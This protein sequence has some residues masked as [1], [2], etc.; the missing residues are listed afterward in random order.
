MTDAVLALVPAY[1]SL[2]L[3]LAVGLSCLG[4]P[5]PG[6]VAL[7]LSGSF[8]ATGEMA[9]LPVLI[10]ALAGAVAGDLTGYAIGRAGGVRLTGWIDSRRSLA[11][12]VAR[13]RTFTERWGVLSVFLTRWLVSPLGPAVNLLSGLTHMAWLWF[14]V[15][16]VAGEIV[17][18]GLYLTLGYFFSTSIVAIAGLLGDL[19]WLVAFF[20]LTAALVW[21][22]RAILRS[23][24]ARHQEQP[25]AGH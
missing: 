23:R 2:A 16:V 18:V 12:A 25:L 24:R 15:A 8:V 9:L 20:I 7:L 14:A 4:V 21:R 5:I 19:T 11:A 17:W 10:A 1:G 3:I 13:A 6:S 22:A